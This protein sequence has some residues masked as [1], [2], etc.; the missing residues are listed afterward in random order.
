[1]TTTKSQESE[2]LKYL[3]SGQSLT[4]LEALERFGSFRLGARVFSLKKQGH[5][6][7]AE[8]IEFRGKRFAK[9]SMELK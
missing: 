9:Y 4:P 7:I 5:P 3:Q 8:M 1:M 2:I 6:I